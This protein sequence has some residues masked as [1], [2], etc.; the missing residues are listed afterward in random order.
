MFRIVGQPSSPFAA[1]IGEVTTQRMP[2]YD[3]HDRI[4]LTNEI[5]MGCVGYLAVLSTA[6]A[7]NKFFLP[8]MVGEIGNGDVNLFKQG[9]IVS[10]SGTGEIL[11]LWKKD[12]RQNS[13]MLTEACNCRCI[14]C[15]QPPKK[16]DQ[17]LF[18]HVV[19]ILDLLKGKQVENICITGG[20]PTIISD[21][22][23]KILHRCNTEHPTAQVSILTNA[24]NFSDTEFSR[25]VAELHQDNDIFC[26]SLHSD[27]PEI[28]DDIVGIPGSYDETNAGIYNLAKSS[29][30]IEIRHVVIRQNYTRLSEFAE[31]MYRYFPFCTHYALMSMETCGIA[32]DNIASIYIDA[33]DYKS[34]LRKAV[35]AMHK[36]GLHVSVYNTQLCLCHEDIR[37]FSRQS[38]SA[39]KNNFHDECSICNVKKECCG[40]FSTSSVQSNNISP[41]I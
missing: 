34:E 8:R 35:L 32:N 6:P 15:P 18:D 16:H 33:Y 36:R 12:S 5:D 24:K 26:V 1:V 3:R 25:A 19:R 10:V 4:L 2:F 41:I 30:P 37:S 17:I 38:I 20:E 23:L 9:D 28:H 7:E 29:F 11:I 13:L 21:N 22:F 39:W 27:I 14:M 40:F 31:H